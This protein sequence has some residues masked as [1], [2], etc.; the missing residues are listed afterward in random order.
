MQD[1]VLTLKSS[2]ERE[3]LNG[4]VRMNLVLLEDP[5][6]QGT[7]PAFQPIV[8][9]KAAGG[10]DECNEREALPEWTFFFQCGGSSVYSECEGDSKNPISI[11]P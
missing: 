11:Q 8:G 5:V 4:I 10:E 9:E 6:N 7:G 1:D 3:A 2:T